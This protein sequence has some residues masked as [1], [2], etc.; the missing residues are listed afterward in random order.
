MSAPALIRQGDAKRL[1]AAARE[2]GWQS[3]EISLD[4]NGRPRLTA[5]S[6]PVS[7]VLARSETETWSD[8]DR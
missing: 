1:L 5:S 7:L 2:A 3:C 6:L 4:D 8:D